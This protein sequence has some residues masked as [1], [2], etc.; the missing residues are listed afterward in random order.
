M[1]EK[2]DVSN[3]ADVIENSDIPVLVDFYNDGCIPCRRIAPL[4]S[5]AEA[6]CDGKIKFARVNIGMNPELT[7]KY[8]VEAAPT[9]IVFRNGAEISRHRGA[10]DAETVQKF[11]E[12]IE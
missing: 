6:S 4:L 10:A 5:K 7:E 1:A 3:F 11:I 12:T 2:L 8:A 9:L